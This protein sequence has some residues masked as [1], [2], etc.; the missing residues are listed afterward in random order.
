MAICLRCEAG[1]A[2]LHKCNASA[3]RG[4]AELIS[5]G[6]REG[7]GEVGRLGGFWDS[8]TRPS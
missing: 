5:A 2:G 1:N 4:L 3:A 7:G 8:S 6:P